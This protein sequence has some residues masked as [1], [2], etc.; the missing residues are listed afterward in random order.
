[1]AGFVPYPRAIWFGYLTN[2]ALVLATIY[3]GLSLANTIFPIPTNPSS[4][5]DDP[6]NTTETDVLSTRIKITWVLFTLAAVAQKMVTV[7]YWALL[8]PPGLPPIF[9]ISMIV[10]YGGVCVLIL[11]DGLLVNRIPIR[12][13]H[14]LELYLPLFLSWIIWLLVQSPLGL[15]L[16]NAYM[17]AI[18]FDV[19]KIY[20]V[21]DWE[22]APMTT[23]ALVSICGFVISPIVHFALSALSMVGRKD[24][25]ANDKGEDIENGDFDEEIISV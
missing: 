13:R 4:D 7:L 5:S 17:D 14:W 24:I 12:M 19:D 11:V 2:W 6:K 23:L 25:N 18:G 16:N 15:Y 3:S 22:S 9:L 10:L 8:H 20:P 1:M 21:V